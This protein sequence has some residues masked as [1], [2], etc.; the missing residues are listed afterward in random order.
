MLDD[1]E[2]DLKCEKGL[3]LFFTLVSFKRILQVLFNLVR[4][5]KERMI[6]HLGKNRS[7]ASTFEYFAYSDTDVT[8]E[9]ARKCK[10]IFT[11]NLMDRYQLDFAFVTNRI[12][13]SQRD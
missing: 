6:T 8:I 5:D 7:I 3:N 1:L 9:T 12:I 10:Q 2:A 4:S 13:P 11:I